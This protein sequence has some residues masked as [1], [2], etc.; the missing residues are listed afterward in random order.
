MWMRETEKKKEEAWR[1]VKEITP[2]M[3]LNSVYLRFPTKMVPH[4][5]LTP[6][7]FPQLIFFSLVSE[8]NI[9]WPT[10]IPSCC[11]CFFFF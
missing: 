1:E 6:Q 2:A 3:S 8:S 4:F 10:P 9:F 11:C 5:E 7:G